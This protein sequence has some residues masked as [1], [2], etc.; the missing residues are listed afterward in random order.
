MLGTP[1]LGFNEQ[2]VRRELGDGGGDSGGV[3]VNFLHH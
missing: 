3:T 2:E 1:G